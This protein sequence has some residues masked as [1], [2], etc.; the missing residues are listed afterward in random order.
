MP[1]DRPTVPELVEAVREFMENEVQPNLEGSVAFHTRVAVNVLRIVERELALVNHAE[2]FA[3]Q[4]DVFFRYGKNGVGILDYKTR[5][6]KPGEVVKAYDNQSMQLAAYAA[7]YWGEDRIG[8]VLAANVF[9]SST[10]PGR[11]DV[12]KHTN[13]SADWEAFKLIAALWRYQKGYDPR[14]KG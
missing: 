12:V 9:I 8:D 6:T 1:T 7:T 11:M 2:G 3:G 13:L 10:E 5:K 14:G 4:S